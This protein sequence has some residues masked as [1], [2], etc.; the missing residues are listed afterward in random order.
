MNVLRP[1]VC[2]LVCCA[3]A[4]QQAPAPPDPVIRVT[5]TL[6]QVDAVVTD[7]SGKPIT[8][9]NRDD[10]QILQDGKPR[11]ITSFSS[12]KVAPA[13]F[14][15]PK[16]STTDQP[17]LSLPI[18]EI[19]RNQIHRTLAILVDDLSIV[20]PGDT[21][22][23]RDAIR[24][25]IDEDVLESD[26]VSVTTSSG[27]MGIYGQFT[28]N[29]EVLHA[30]A[31]SI[32]WR[33]SRPEFE[34]RLVLSEETRALQAGTIG[35]IREAMRGLRDM[36][37]RRAIVLFSGGLERN[38]ESEQ[39]LQELADE[40]TRF[41]VTVYTIDAEG[42][43][44]LRANAESASKTPGDLSGR[45]ISQGGLAMLARQTG[46]LFYQNTNDLEGELVEALDDQS[47]YYA[48]G[49]NPGDDSFDRRFHQIQVRVLRDG[50]SVRS[51]TGY[52]GETQPP[53]RVRLETLE[54]QTIRAMLAP[55]QTTSIRTRLTSL[56]VIQDKKP[57]VTS[58]LYVDA[59]DLQFERAPEN[60]FQ[61]TFEVV[62][63]NFDS[64]G[65]LAD[66]VAKRY[67]VTLTA[68]LLAAARQYGLSYTFSYRVKKPGPYHVRMAVRDVT[69]SK[70]G[71]AS[72]FLVVPDLSKNRL[73]LSGILLGEPEGIEPYPLST[74]ALRVFRRGRNMIWQAQV[75]NPKLK[76]NLPKLLSSVRILREG[77]VL[78]EI[79]SPVD[80]ANLS[81]NGP[82]DVMTGGFVT[83][84]ER[85]EAGDYVLQLLVRDENDGS[86]LVTQTIDFQVV[87]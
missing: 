62:V 82:R 75:L 80:I 79:A 32:R 39:Y 61:S 76:R 56:F 25:F 8:N 23:V 42:L 37:G 30:A 34:D 41:A 84:G 4:G 67:M 15:R 48:L 74:P 2:I 5:T 20:G 43:E 47:S 78:S 7:R 68:E 69:S 58:A 10:F 29:R 70:I 72:Q 14:E 16:R 51:R 36:P 73:V 1:T 19:E 60:K 9:L 44:T 45:F 26:L 66:S 38:P 33:G 50:L 13:S 31:D 64:N 28:T 71:T 85:M 53:A 24:K 46:G 52:L 3:A 35:A 81:P 54:K 57:Y 27:G 87:E 6:V 11:S 12:V 21:A 55:F 65:R 49:Y 86:K 18:R 40:A 22:R 59:N 83:L 63:A 17:L 77:K